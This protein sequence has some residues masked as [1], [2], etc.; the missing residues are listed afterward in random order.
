VSKRVVQ[1][2]DDGV[3]LICTAC[4]KQKPRDAFARAP[5]TSR[6]GKAYGGFGM[7]CKQCRKDKRESPQGR[8]WAAA[9][10]KKQERI[11]AMRVS[12]AKWS[13]EHV[14]A[15]LAY[16]A[17]EDAKKLSRKRNARYYQRH[18]PRLTEQFRTIYAA[19]NKL[20]TTKYR[21]T[22][23]GRDTM[24]LVSQR[25][26]AR[27]R[28]NGGN[29]TRR[30]WRAVVTAHGNRCVYCMAISKQ[31]S[32]DHVKAIASGGRHDVYNVVPACMRCNRAKSAMPLVDAL[33]KLKVDPL[34]FIF[35]R[36]V[37]LL[38]LS[39]AQNVVS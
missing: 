36:N 11:T 23:K 31:L 12:R 19:C 18:K 35:R 27:T 32:I 6:P 20:A 33:A 28:G 13:L 38:N 39:R 7:P 10:S 2:P 21:A 14:D 15:V 26:R 24:R 5:L 8:A 29:L 3:T 16:R 1:Q 4:K 9:H 22:E 17:S 30:E 25:R 37:A 34:D